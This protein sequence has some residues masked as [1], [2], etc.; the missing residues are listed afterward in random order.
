MSVYNEAA[1]FTKS[2][3]GKVASKP[4]TIAAET[5]SLFNVSG[6]VVVTSLVGVVTT[7]M[8]VANTVKL[9]V[10]PTTGTSTDMCTATDLGTTDTPAGN[11]LTLPAAVGSAMTNS[12]GVGLP[13]RGFFQVAAGTI[14][15]I[16]TGTSPDGAITW[17]LT[18]VPLVDGATVV[19]A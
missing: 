10:N 16:T 13:G 1:A 18:Y 9:T 6:L 14:E 7:A 19:A 4:Y 2:V 11:L 15:Q 5:K 8:T 12:I 3:L 17:Y